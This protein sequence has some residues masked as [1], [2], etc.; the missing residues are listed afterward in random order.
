MLIRKLD[1]ALCLN[2][3]K[4]WGDDWDIEDEEDKGDVK[5]REKCLTHGLNKFQ[6]KT[7]II[8][9]KVSKQTRIKEG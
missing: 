2:D 1:C 7:P 5:F 9:E 8:T 3:W 4:C 6:A